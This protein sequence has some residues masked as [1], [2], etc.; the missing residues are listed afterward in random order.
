MNA[1]QRPRQVKE[2][3]KRTESLAK[4]ARDVAFCTDVDI[5]LICYKTTTMTKTTWNVLPC[6]SMSS[7][8]FII[9][10]LWIRWVGNWICNVC[11]LVVFLQLLVGIWMMLPLPK[12]TKLLIHVLISKIP[13]AIWGEL[14]N[15]FA[16]DQFGQVSLK[17]WRLTRARSLGLYNSVYV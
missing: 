5:G 16:S 8:I 10:A 3:K 17:R 2:F 15:L 11:L 12:S 9:F 4:R 1:V 7:F 14:R 6:P 13:W